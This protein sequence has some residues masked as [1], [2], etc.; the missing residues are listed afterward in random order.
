M[1]TYDRIIQKCMFIA[2]RV[3]LSFWR[4]ASD[5]EVAL[6]EDLNGRYSCY[7][8]LSLDDNEVCQL[9]A[10]RALRLFNHVPLRTRRAQLLYEV[11]RWCAF[12]F[13]MEHGWTAWMPFV[14]SADD[15]S[16][17]D[18]SPCNMFLLC[19]RSCIQWNLVIT[20]SLGPWKLPCYI[21]FLI[22]R[23]KNKEI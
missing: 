7:P 3:L 9:R 17:L 6:V 22:I 13:S 23:V 5:W 21:R 10:R 18:I 12:W 14:L 1:C 8:D 11:W 15:C 19:S 2:T 16:S 20:R 4:Q